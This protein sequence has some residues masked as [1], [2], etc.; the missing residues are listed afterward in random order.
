[1][2]LAPPTGEH[3][4]KMLAPNGWPE[5]DEDINFDR[6][7]QYMQVL[8]TVSDVADNCHRQ[9]LAIFDGDVWSGS[10]S[11]AAN[12][13]VGTLIEAL[14][15]L[16]DGLAT[17]ITWHRNIGRSIIQAKSDIYDNVEVAETKIKA[18]ANEFRLTEAE[19]TEAISA[20]VT[21][22]HEANVAVVT[23]TAEQIL[24][25]KAWKPPSGA[26]QD[27]L[28]Q[29]APPLGLGDE[30]PSDS[31]PALP[32]PVAPPVA[33]PI[34]SPP[35]GPSLPGIPVGGQLPTPAII[36]A[37]PATAGASAPGHPTQVGGP[38]TAGA[39]RRP[40]TVSREGGADDPDGSALPDAQPYEVGPHDD[41]P[42]VAPASAG[43]MPA[44]PAV[45]GAAGGGGAGG[46][47]ASGGG[48]GGGGLFYT[49]DAADDTPC[50]DLGGRRVFR[51]KKR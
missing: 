19:R 26:L 34:A 7:A 35:A 42:R 47:V 51:K 31:S 10:A 43:V 8:R 33:G 37:M 28:D 49:S 23:I 6:A 24:A 44:M 27:L 32:G 48:P 41:S 36:P 13:Q 9:Q 39:V 2:G 4:E 5:S 25:S 40:A 38:A 45:P 15:S 12:R 1:M 14:T 17:V 22:T 11:G 21:A 3:A 50:G 18:L 20:V 16:Q 29:K 30:D 46:S